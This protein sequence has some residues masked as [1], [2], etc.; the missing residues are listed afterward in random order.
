[1]VGYSNGLFE[2]LLVGVVFGN[3]VGKLV[4]PGDVVVFTVGLFDVLLDGKLVGIYEG[5]LLR[6][7]IEFVISNIV[8]GLLGNIACSFVDM[9][10]GEECWICCR[11]CCW[12]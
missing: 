2:G 1:V 7:F 9:I 8:K 6:E 5:L 11:W 10:V 12:I 4:G 3:S